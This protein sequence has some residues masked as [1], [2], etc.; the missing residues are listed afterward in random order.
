MAVRDAAAEAGSI[1]APPSTAIAPST[2]IARVTVVRGV[3]PNIPRK[4]NIP[5]PL[6]R[7]LSLAADL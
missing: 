5:A 4:E 6:T 2:V 3:S 7:C 1:P